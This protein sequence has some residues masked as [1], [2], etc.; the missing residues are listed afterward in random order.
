MQRKDVII[1]GAGQAGL[2]MSC[3]LSEMN[4]E[5]V[6]LER[7][8]VANSWHTE[9]WDSLRLLTPNW[10][11]RLPRFSYAGDDPDGFRTMPQTVEFLTAYARH[12][13][14]P[15]ETRTTVLSVARTDEGYR[16]IT[17]RGAWRCRA[18][19][20]ASGACNRPSV[21]ACAADLPDDATSLT[22]MD[23]KNPHQLERGGVLVVGASATGVQLA[24]E[25]QRSGRPVYLVTGEHVRV[26]RMYRGRDI[27]WWMD[28][29]GIL[30]MGPADVG[31]LR[32]AREVPSL[33]LIGSPKRETI[34]LNTLQAMGVTVTGRLTGING[35]K[36]Q[37]S[38]S[39]SNVC[40]LADLK[41]NRL[42]QH[43]DEW[44][45][46]HGLSDSLVEPYRP[47][48]T[49]LPQSPLLELDLRQA[50]IRT[51]VWATGYRPDYSWLEV[52]VLTPRGE[53][54]HEGG[55]VASPGLYVLGLPFL[56]KRKSSLIDG[57]GDDATALSAH[58]RAYLNGE[59]SIA[60]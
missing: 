59:T 52:P 3:R 12:I 50:G 49:H 25:I 4:I 10:Q 9:R 17:D 57:V 34:D 28:A 26:P 16:V 22:P 19:V 44:I 23:Y 11:S 60:A 27:K 30:E 15:V 51:V 21:P 8:R 32:R 40:T 36:L 13:L 45:A 18:L 14:A 47:A 7:G 53:L 31:D 37:F 48:P 5:H 1:I 24:A 54:R 39:L 42:L 58:V 35:Q 46:D 20:L 56:R 33:Q 6:V 29:T 41:M 55:V 43:I 2:A 38:G